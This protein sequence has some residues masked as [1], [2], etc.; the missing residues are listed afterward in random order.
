MSSGNQLS[1]SFQFAHRPSSVV[2][3]TGSPFARDDR[4]PHQRREEHAVEPGPWLS[5]GIP[6]P[7]FH[8]QHHRSQSG[9]E[10]DIDIGE[11]RRSLG[12]HRR[13]ATPNTIRRSA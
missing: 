1:V 12:H 6:A 9:E 8:E 7:K 10:S 13:R 4:L 2:Q 5:A 3:T 11:K